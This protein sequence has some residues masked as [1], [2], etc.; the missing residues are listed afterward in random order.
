MK[1][2]VILVSGGL[3]SSTVLA[4]QERKNDCAIYAIS[5]NYAQNHLIE[6]AKIKEFIKDY[7]IVS[8]HIIN[9]DLSAFDSTSLVNKDLSVPK[10]QSNEAVGQQIPNTYVPARNSIFLSYALG[11]AENIGA[12]DIFIG[13]HRSDEANYPDCRPDYLAAF[14]EMANLAT[15]VGRQALEKGS[16]EEK[17]KI[18]APLINLTKSDIVAMG[19]KIGVDYSKTIS[20]YHPDS[21]HRSCGACLSCLVRLQAFA[22]NK[23]VDPVEY[24][25]NT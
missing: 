15:K 6:L 9:L 10:Y 14:T 16:E 8:H 1:K 4:M 19:L 23:T 22:D 7:K 25:K 2:I 12:R 11:F 21:L 24:Y 5:F 18:H 20:C 3:D 13:A 17:I